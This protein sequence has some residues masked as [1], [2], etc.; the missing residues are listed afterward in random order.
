MSDME[1]HKGIAKEICKDLEGFEAKVHYA[2][3]T[4]GYEVEDCDVEGESFWSRQL[5]WV[6]GKLFCLDNTSF[7]YPENLCSA[8]PLRDGSFAYTLVFYNGG[9]CFGEEISETLKDAI[10]SQ[11]G[12]GK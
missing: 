10:N 12:E 9:T 2:V 5:A 4:L 7:D 6:H 3:N 8:M 1:Y 11:E